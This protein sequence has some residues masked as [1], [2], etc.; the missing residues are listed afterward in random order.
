[1]NLSNVPGPDSVIKALLI[2]VFGPTA[3]IVVIFTIVN[4]A[5]S[6][7]GVAKS[8]VRF[9][10][11]SAAAASK[12]YTRVVGMR[13]ASVALKLL[14]TTL[15]LVLQLVWLWSASR[16]ANGLSYLW[17]APFGQG[18]PEWSGL[19]SYVRWDWISTSYMMASVVALVACYVF[20]FGSGKS[21]VIGNGTIALQSTMTI[22]R[23]W[24]G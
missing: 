6:W 20:A 11:R 19:V 5:W 13:P 7:F 24:R 18:N 14:I 16:I 17:A 12:A 1:M 15:V 8:G 3:T 10:R 23:I 4:V 9:G 2:G 21:D 22:A